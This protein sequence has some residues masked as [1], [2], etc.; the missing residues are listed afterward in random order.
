MRDDTQSEIASAAL[1]ELHEKHAAF[2]RSV[3]RLENKGVNGGSMD[4]DG[5][6]LRV[7]CLGVSFEVSAR[8][9]AK[10]GYPSALEYPF[11]A[12]VREKNFLVWRMYLDPDG[13]LY[14]DPGCKTR[15]CD[16]TN[17]RLPEYV[18]E[19]LATALLK[20]P[21]FQPLQ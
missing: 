3:A 6:T 21:V 1:K 16:S 4:S 9:V 19:A 18:I 17:S 8:P 2:M 13:G 7:V 5:Q 14:S 10:D 20:S 12:T 15:I 11:F